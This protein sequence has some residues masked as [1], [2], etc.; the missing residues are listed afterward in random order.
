MKSWFAYEYGYI[1]VDR[2][3]V[4]FTN[5]GNGSELRRLKEIPFGQNI[6][7]RLD[8]YTFIGII[9]VPT[10][11]FMI[12]LDYTFRSVLILSAIFTAIYFAYQYLKRE[13]E[14]SMWI[15]MDRLTNIDIELD[16]V[17]VSYLNVHGKIK[18]IELDKVE[19]DGIKFWSQL[20][21]SLNLETL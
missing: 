5:T 18:S 3:N 16:F 13:K 15:P 17:E 14:V 12:D 11:Y 7:N 1:N 10:F 2:D 8:P 21:E 4:Y 20:R 19:K 9:S 6:S